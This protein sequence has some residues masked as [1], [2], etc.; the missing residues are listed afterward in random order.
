VGSN[1]A[2]CHADYPV[3]PQFA[4][5]PTGE[6]GDLKMK[7]ILVAAFVFTLTLFISNPIWVSAEEDIQTQES[8]CA[9]R[10]VAGDLWADVVIGQ[11]DFTEINPNEIVPDKVFN[12]G[13]V[14]I[15]NSGSIPGKAYVW[16][17]NNNSPLG[18]RYRQKIV[19]MPKRQCQ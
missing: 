4:M 9:I 5:N 15:D 8:S 11:R 16:D 17:S 2:S 19:D 3:L 18:N 10:G 12:P 6:R 7:K 14:V 1:I 13:G